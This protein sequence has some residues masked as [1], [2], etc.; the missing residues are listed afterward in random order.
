MTQA[1]NTLSISQFSSKTNRV[2][3]FSRSYFRKPTY[4]FSST[5]K[6]GTCHKVKCFVKTI[7]SQSV[8]PADT[9]HFCM[10]KMG[11]NGHLKTVVCITFQL[12]AL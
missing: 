1:A 11:V 9:S 4:G 8:N 2:S 3:T 7:D 6:M 10:N 12:Q 5:L